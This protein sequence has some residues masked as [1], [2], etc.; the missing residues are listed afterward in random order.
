VIADRM[1]LFVN[2]VYEAPAEFQGPALA[3]ATVAFAI[4]IYC[5]FSGYSDIA[6]GSAQVMGIRLMKNFNHPYFSKSIPE[7]WRRWHISLSTWFRDYVYIPLGGNRLGSRRMAVN[8]FVTFLISGLWHGANWTF[9]IWG[10]L[11][12]LYV[13]LNGFID[14]YWTRLRETIS[15]KRFSAAFDVA[16]LLTTL[17][18]VC[19]AWIFFR[20]ASLSDASY[21]VSHLFTGWNEQVRLGTT[22]FADGLSAGFWGLVNG[23]F[24]FL[25]TLTPLTRSE[26]FLSGIALVFLLY[27]E[28]HQH[29]DNFLE[30]INRQP[31]WTRRLSYSLLIAIT[32]ALG[33]SYSGV[34]QAF[35]YF[36]F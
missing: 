3:L 34:Q 28:V 19:F 13:V 35:I 14:P 2:P 30:T 18:L 22:I 16:S 23:M 33:T 10:G 8:L 17:F 6:F 25:K 32:L 20:A 24:N 29:R 7:F 36:Q 4:Q 31:P 26:I 15:M 27:V 9:V 5:D 21:I 12:G 1:A 11:H